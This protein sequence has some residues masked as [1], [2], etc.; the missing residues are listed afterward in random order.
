MKGNEDKTIHKS[1][2][3][4]NEIHERLQGLNE[5]LKPE[6]VIKIF[7]TKKEVENLIGIHNT[8]KVIELLKRTRTIHVVK[9][10]K[11][12]R[13]V[14]NL[15]QNYFSKDY[16]ATEKIIKRYEEKGKRKLKDL[17]NHILKLKSKRD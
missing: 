1:Y 3:L 2:K 11:K 5:E 7:P 14:L 15:A 16:E 10:K 6:E 9:H 17:T 8:K 4:V 12:N 13:Y